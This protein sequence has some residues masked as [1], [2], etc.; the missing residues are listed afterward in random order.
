LAYRC[1]RHG[2]PVCAKG[3]ID[4]NNTASDVWADS[5]YRS[6]ENERFLAN[7]GK[8][9]PIHRHKA[10]GK[11]MSRRTARAKATI[12]LANMIY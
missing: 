12:T 3:L 7:I 10:K 8:I 2:G 1:G 11:P 4:P 5:A 6:A 9:G